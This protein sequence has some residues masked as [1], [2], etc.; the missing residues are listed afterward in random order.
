[1]DITTTELKT[2]KI[3]QLKQLIKEIIQETT[4]AGKGAIEKIK[5][6]SRFNSLDTGAK[7]NSISDLS[8][9]G[10]VELEE[11]ARLAKGFKLADE[12]MDMSSY[13][14]LQVTTQNLDANGRQIRVTLADVLEYIKENPGLEKKDI[15]VHFNLTTIFKIYSKSFPI[16]NLFSYKSPPHF[17]FFLSFSFCYLSCIRYSLKKF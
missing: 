1:M 17:K 2:M 8:K 12:N 7:T 11:M 3:E 13:V 10:D 5:K 14:P 4:Y 15:F 16:L 9:G 6:D